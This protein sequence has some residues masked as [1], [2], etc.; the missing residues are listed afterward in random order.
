[1]ASALK[2]RQ[3]ATAMLSSVIHVCHW[4][5]CG[6]SWWLCSD[7]REACGRCGEP[8]R[9]E[10][11]TGY[12]VISRALSYASFEAVGGTRQRALVLDGSSARNA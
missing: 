7:G 5:T 1:M 11:L 8:S 4:I 9:D 3:E 6:R 12:D 2:L 10:P